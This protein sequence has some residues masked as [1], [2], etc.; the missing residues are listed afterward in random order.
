MIWWPFTYDP[1]WP[2]PLWPIWTRL[3]FV[4]PYQI[5][6]S[7]LLSGATHWPCQSNAWRENTWHMATEWTTKFHTDS[8]PCLWYSPSNY[9]NDDYDDDDDILINSRGW[10]NNGDNGH[11]IEKYISQG[12]VATLSRCGGA[13]MTALL[14][15]IAE[16][17]CDII[18][19]IDHYVSMLQG[20]LFDWQWPLLCHNVIH[21]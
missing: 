3:V 13:F 1:T 14:L 21:H 18:L 17:Y 20:N 19:K 7:V 2:D 5:R 9:H 8:F 16:C 6:R 11:C 15:I 12:S 4:S 10:R